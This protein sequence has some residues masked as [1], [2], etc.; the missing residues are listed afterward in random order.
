[1]YLFFEKGMRSAVSYIGKGYSKTDNKY[2]TSHDPKK[3]AKHI[4]ILGRE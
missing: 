3:E 2:L 4:I 1:M